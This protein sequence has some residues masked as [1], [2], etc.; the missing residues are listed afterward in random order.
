MKW[1]LIRPPRI[2]RWLF[3]EA[4]FR[5]PKEKNT[6]YLTFDDGPHPEATDHVLRVLES[7]G[8][9]A[10]FFLLGKNAKK[11]AE[12]VN[13]IRKE[14]HM[15]ANHG[16]N[17]L[18]GWDTDTSTYLDDVQKG[19]E[20]IGS[21]VF[22]P[23]YGKLGFWQYLRLRKKVKIV[24]WDVISGD[25]DEKADGNQVVRNVL[26]KTRNGSI[27][28]MHDSRKA[29]PNL[30]ASLNEIITQLSEKGFSFGTIDNLLEHKIV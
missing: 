4:I 7:H 15:T 11:Y 14:G 24:F 25:F 1:Y 5:G 28:V 18:N 2:Y 10:T 20:Q 8:V 29:L 30:K 6:V 16:M 3:S 27:I 23:P 13:R 12:L 9:K 26:T 17:H 19:E 22:R 21:A